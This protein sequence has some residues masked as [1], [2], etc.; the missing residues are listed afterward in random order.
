MTVFSPAAVAVISVSRNIDWVNTR[1]I[2]AA[3]R[4]AVDHAIPADQST[5]RSSSLLESGDILWDDATA[6]LCRR[7]LLAIA[8][9]LEATE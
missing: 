7:R 6:S 4:A 8:E 9:E 2:A 1:Q 3:I 5:E